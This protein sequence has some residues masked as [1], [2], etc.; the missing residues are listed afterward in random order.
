MEMFL[1]ECTP[2]VAYIYCASEDSWKDRTP[3]WR[4]GGEAS[5]SLTGNVQ[6]DESPRGFLE[7][8]HH[9]SNISLVVNRVLLH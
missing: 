5:K 4:L 9:A 3:G 8:Y 7:S 2:L 6:I 1:K